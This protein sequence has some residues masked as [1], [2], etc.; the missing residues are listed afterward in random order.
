MA[1]R[2][3]G[4]DLIRYARASAGTAVVDGRVVE[5]GVRCSGCGQRLANY[6]ARP[7]EFYCR[8]CRVSL[9]SA[10]GLTR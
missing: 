9:K 7:Y 4:W 2:A 5:K 1:S 6:A 3:E 8:R 10:P